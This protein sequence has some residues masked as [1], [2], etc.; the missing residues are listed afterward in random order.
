[1]EAAKCLHWEEGQHLKEIA[2]QIRSLRG[3]FGRPN[4]LVERFLHYFSMRGANIPGEPKLAKA[5][6]DEIQKGDFG[7]S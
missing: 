4:Q 7:H 1:M 6:L 3:E 5:F 2:L